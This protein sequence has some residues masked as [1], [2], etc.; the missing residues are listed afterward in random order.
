MIKYVVLLSSASLVGCGSCSSVEVRRDPVYKISKSSSSVTPRASR[1][2]SRKSD[3]IVRT[4][5]TW[6]A[7][8]LIDSYKKSHPAKVKA[9]LIKYGNDH[10]LVDIHLARQHIRSGS[11]NTQ[12]LVPALK[13]LANVES[14]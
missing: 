6:D 2:E 7:A 8:K 13:K 11:R 12:E 10:R 9:L 5:T 1:S 3:A 4:P 14:R